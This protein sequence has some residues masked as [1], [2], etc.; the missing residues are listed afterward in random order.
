MN[1][2]IYIDELLNKTI[3]LKLK[4]DILYTISDYNV[5]HHIDSIIKKNNNIDFIYT[6]ITYL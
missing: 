4:Y 1:Q 3:W 6:I 5:N 2:H